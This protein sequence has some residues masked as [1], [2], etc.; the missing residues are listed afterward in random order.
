MKE[1]VMYVKLPEGAKYRKVIVTDDGSIGIVYSEECKCQH[2]MEGITKKV[3]IPKPKALVGGCEVYQKDDV[4][5]WY[6]KIKNGR[7]EFMHLYMEDLTEEDLL[8][9]SK[10][11]KERTFSTNNQ[12]KFKKYVLEAINNKPKEGY[13]W[14]PVFEPSLTS[15]GEVQFVKGKNP[16]VECSCHNWENMFERYSTENESSKGSKT[17]YFLLLL[18]WLK[19]GFATLEEL[20]DNSRKIGHYWNSNNAKQNLELT[21]EREFGGLYGFVGNT[22]KIVGDSNSRSGFSLLGGGYHQDGNIHPLAFFLYINSPYTKNY[23]SVGLL[24]LKK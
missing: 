4:P 20:A 2:K 10:T 17:T 23:F 6:C 16:L 21:G 22:Y 19:D 3:E 1:K 7:D 9:D 12:K 8:Y 14:I 11:G 18:R 24:E 13:R 5:Y 15:N